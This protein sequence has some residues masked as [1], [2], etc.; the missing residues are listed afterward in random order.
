MIRVSYLL[1]TFLS[2]LL[3]SSITKA[4]PEDAHRIPSKWE[5]VV[6]IGHP[7]NQVSEL[8]VNDLRKIVMAESTNWQNVGGVDR[9]I[10]IYM[11]QAPGSALDEIMRSVLNAQLQERIQKES[12]FNSLLLR[13]SAVE[14]AIGLVPISNSVQLRNLLDQTSIKVFPIKWDESSNAVLPSLEAML[15]GLYP[16]I[17]RDYAPSERP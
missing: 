15:N 5:I 8:S 11:L 10:E 7:S 9:P 12:F 4:N 16:L 6:I 14:G 13:V 2:L 1:A 17:W 3:C